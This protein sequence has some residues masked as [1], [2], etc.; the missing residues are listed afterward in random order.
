MSGRGHK[1]DDKK[2][3]KDHGADEQKLNGVESLLYRREDHLS[4]GLAYRVSEIIA[5]VD[6]AENY[7]SMETLYEGAMSL[8][9]MGHVA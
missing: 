9:S 7:N 8:L 6:F 3:H 2:H 1:I 5:M 4:L